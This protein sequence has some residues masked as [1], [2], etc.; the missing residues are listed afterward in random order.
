MELPLWIKRLLCVHDYRT[1][2]EVSYKDYFISNT[3][4]GYQYVDRYI[5]V[6]KC[7]KCNKVKIDKFKSWWL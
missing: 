4:S 1:V 6:N 7:S 2:K 5:Q 3:Y